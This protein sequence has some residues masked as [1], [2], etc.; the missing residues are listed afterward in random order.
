MTRAHALSH[1]FIIKYVIDWQFTI[2]IIH[3]Q[4][5]MYTRLHLNSIISHHVLYS[6]PHH[7]IIFVQKEWRK[8]IGRKMFDLL[9]VIFIFFAHSFFNSPSRSLARSLVQSFHKI[10]TNLDKLIAF[11]VSPVT[12]SDASSSSNKLTFCVI[13]PRASS[14][15]S[16]LYIFFCECLIWKR[17]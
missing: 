15:L 1:C 4:K 6:V 12:A 3:T 13:L 7:Q 17:L 10:I 11:C 2:E 16:L 5:Y 8:K 14:S 9:P